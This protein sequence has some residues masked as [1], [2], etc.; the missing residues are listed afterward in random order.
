MFTL[1]MSVH[2]IYVVYH[3]NRIGFQLP[4]H[5]KLETDVSWYLG[6]RNWTEV[7]QKSCQ[8]FQ[9]TNHSLSPYF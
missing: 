7:I 6:S 8:W 3:E 2:L 1:S 5:L 9:T 4:L